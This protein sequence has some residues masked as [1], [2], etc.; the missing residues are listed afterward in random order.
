MQ[1]E[2]LFEDYTNADGAPQNDVRRK[3]NI[4]WHN[5]HRVEKNVAEED[6]TT[7]LTAISHDGEFTREILHA[8]NAI[9]FLLIP[10]ASWGACI[11]GAVEAQCLLTY[12]TSRATSS[13]KVGVI[14]LHYEGDED[15]WALYHNKI[16]D[17]YTIEAY[18]FSFR[19]NFSPQEMANA[20]RKFFHVTTVARDTPI[21]P[22]EATHWQSSFP[23]YIANVKAELVKKDL[24][25]RINLE[26]NQ[27]IILL[28][29]G[30]SWWARC[31]ATKEHAVMLY[32]T[33]V[34]T[35][36]GESERVVYVSLYPNHDD[37]SGF[38]CYPPSF[39]DFKQDFVNLLQGVANKN[40][41]LEAYRITFP[42]QRDVVNI[43]TAYRKYLLNVNNHNVQF[44]RWSTERP[45]D[46]SAY[47]PDPATEFYLC[48]WGVG[49]AWLACCR[50]KPSTNCVSLIVSLLGEA[51][52]Y[53]SASASTQLWTGVAHALM[54]LAIG[55]LLSEF[56][57]LIGAEYPVEQADEGIKYCLGVIA[58]CILMSLATYGIDRESVQKCLPSM[59]N[60]FCCN[61]S[62]TKLL[63][64]G[65]DLSKPENVGTLPKT[66]YLTLAVISTIVAI[67]MFIIR[68][69]EH[70]FSEHFDHQKHVP[71][72]WVT[73]TV[74]A[75]VS[76]IA[77]SLLSCFASETLSC[78]RPVM[79][80]RDLRRMAAFSAE[81]REGLTL[82]GYQPPA[83]V[84]EGR[85]ASNRPSNASEFSDGGAG[86]VKLTDVRSTLHSAPRGALPADQAQSETDAVK[87]QV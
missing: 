5:G 51:K 33:Q 2:R 40:H 61:G 6:K 43:H 4:W 23:Q 63:C 83:D 16:L 18:H 44:N 62:L 46:L 64:C 71:I 24:L 53:T 84:E 9:V 59:I 50:T 45:S 66:I 57:R 49:C 38:V 42:D 75:I 37:P 86:S 7:L 76:F 17:K 68:G 65:N 72:I 25:T 28:F 47:V 60:I 67:L 69:A 41:D 30:R 52:L 10:T 39:H 29:I 35:Q 34:S 8:Q 36:A 14:S 82:L 77:Y 31:G 27:V 15:S 85:Q 87:A 78:S 12:R 81:R 3:A 79:L 74:A 22:D 19:E 32:R 55:A 1:V 73:F 20:C 48:Y 54:I 80:H 11:S 58:V 21:K 13:H 26:L 56:A 70:G